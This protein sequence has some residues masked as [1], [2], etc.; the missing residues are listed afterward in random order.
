MKR[1]KLT[2]S[3]PDGNIYDGEVAKISLMGTEGSLSVLAGHV[4]FITTVAAGECQIWTDDESG[5]IAHI[6]GGLL[7][8]SAQGTTLLCGKF[9]K[10]E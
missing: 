2:V 7:T 1:F 9:E 3:T 4:P 5:I 6:D 8:V 10:E